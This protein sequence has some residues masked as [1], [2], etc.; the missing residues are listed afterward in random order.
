[1]ALS[2]RHRDDR[3]A[4]RWLADC[5]LASALNSTLPTPRPSALKLAPRRGPTGGGAN[6]REA[7]CR[8]RTCHSDVARPAA[9]GVDRTI[10]SLVGRPS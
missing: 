10:A 5:R 9:G 8:P 7:V 1:M 2:G 3:S 6:W 4:G